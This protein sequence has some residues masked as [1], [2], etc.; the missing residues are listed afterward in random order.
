MPVRVFN[1]VEAAIR[2]DAEA[3]HEALV[4]PNTELEPKPEHVFNCEMDLLHEHE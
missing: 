3:N 2:Y 1:S 4:D